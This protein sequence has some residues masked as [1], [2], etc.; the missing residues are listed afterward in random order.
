MDLHK[1]RNLCEHMGKTK[2]P[3]TQNP[4]LSSFNTGLVS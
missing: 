1:V 4:V 3:T 2:Q